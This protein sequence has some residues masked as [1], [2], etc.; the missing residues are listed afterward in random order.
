MRRYVVG[1][2][3]D[4][5]KVLLIKKLKPDWQVGFLNGVGGKC[6][7]G[8][9]NNE[10]MAR[11]FHEETGVIIPREDWRLFCTTYARDGTVFFFTTKL[12]NSIVI[13]QMEDEQPIWV[14]H[15]RLYDYKVINNLRWLIP[16]ALAEICVSALVLEIK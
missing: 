3:F 5:E 8:E 11:E 13:K 4:N 2:A 15:K 9:S 7:A 16:M 6:E 12:N 10:A 14:L 1:F